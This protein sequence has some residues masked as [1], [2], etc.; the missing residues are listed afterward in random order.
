[1]PLLLEDYLSLLGN[2]EE[3][4]KQEQEFMD[5]NRCPINPSSD[6]SFGLWSQIYGGCLAHVLVDLPSILQPPNLLVMQRCLKLFL[7]YLFFLSSVLFKEIVRPFTLHP[8]LTLMTLQKYLR[9][10]W[11]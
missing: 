10:A 8:W 11:S 6:Q 9:S 3:C 1:M 2:D 7:A 5:A 4:F